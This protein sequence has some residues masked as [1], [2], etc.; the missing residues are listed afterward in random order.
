MFA[1]SFCLNKVRARFPDSALSG[2]ASLWRWTVNKCKPN[3]YAVVDQVGGQTCAPCPEGA[4]CSDPDATLDTLL[5]LPGWW[6]APW[7]PSLRP[8]SSSTR[9]FYQCLLRSS[10]RQSSCL[11]SNI[12]TQCDA[13]SGFAPGGQLCAHCQKNWVR[14]GFGCA[15]CRATFVVVFVA[16][17]LLL[18]YSIFVTYKVHRARTKKDMELA[19][20]VRSAVQRISITHVV[21]M[22]SL[23]NLNVRSAELVQVPFVLL[24]A[25]VSPFYFPIFINKYLCFAAQMVFGN[26]DILASGVSTSST[27]LRCLLGVGFY[28]RVWGDFLLLAALVLLSILMTFLKNK[29]LNLRLGQ[30]FKEEIVGCV[31]LS[32]YLK[33]PSITAN[34][35]SGSAVSPPH[36]FF[37]I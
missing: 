22:S 31:I 29:A 25:F 34:M 32:V 36:F 12:S 20:I 14:D 18:A 27:A 33:Y 24:I 26:M 5:P 3:E 11:G 15:I 35:L 9:R 17:A 16:S 13:K 37:F 4:D 10:P 30:E 7:P 2:P 23:G 6:V 8:T 19:L 1:F 21:T 28:S